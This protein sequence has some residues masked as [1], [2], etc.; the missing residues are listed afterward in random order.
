MNYKL[1]SLFLKIKKIIYNFYACFFSIRNCVICGV[2]VNSGLLLCSSCEK[3]EFKE[4]LEQQ[5]KNNNT[6]CRQCGTPVI[7]EIDYCI[8][9]KT[10]IHRKEEFLLKR[11][12]SL[13]PYMGAGGETVTVWKNKNERAFAEFFAKSAASFISQT[14][15]LK[16]IPV[17]PMPPRPKKLKVKG[18]DQI[19]DLS[20]YLEAF[21][22]I[23]IMRILKRLDSVPQKTLTKAQ[24]AVNLKGKIILNYL[25][26]L[27]KTLLLIDD[28]ITTG[29]TLNTCAEILKQGGCETVYGLCLFFD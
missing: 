21:Y 11:V 17:V 23:K 10:K 5:I 16:G 27:P 20:K 28:V 29:A 13:F 6:R 15:E 1:I 2:R 22:G 26:P 12:F 4:I 3:K 18:W 19:E 24:R 25:K 9:C 7:S 14:P 8:K